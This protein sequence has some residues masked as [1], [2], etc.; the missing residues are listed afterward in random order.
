MNTEIIATAAAATLEL[1]ASQAR[2]T[3]QAIM[4]TVM[5]DPNG[6]TAAYFHATMAVAIEKAKW[7]AGEVR[8]A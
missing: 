2:S 1:M 4:D 6:A 7:M 3:P 8:A 5:A